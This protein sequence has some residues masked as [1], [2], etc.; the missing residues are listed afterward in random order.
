MASWVQ[1]EAPST[2]AQWRATNQEG[3]AEQ[4][5]LGVDALMPPGL[6]LSPSGYPN[7]LER[8]V[9]AIRRAWRDRPSTDP[10]WF[11]RLC[12][13]DDWL[14]DATLR[15]FAL[16]LV[17]DL[18]DEIGIALHTRFGRRAAGFDQAS[19]EALREFV[20]VLAD[21]GRLIL[22]LQS[23]MVGWLSLAWGAWGFS[24]GLSQTSWLDSREEIRRRRGSR[25]PA[26]LER[27]FEPQLLH[28]VLSSDHTQLS[29]QNGYRSCSCTFCGQ[30]AQGWDTRV[31]GQHD[32]YA[33]A[34]LTQ[35]VA[36]GDR[37]AR[38]DAVRDILEA[39]QNRWA[40]WSATPGLSPRARPAQLATW[41]AVV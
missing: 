5:S 6:E 25:S 4:R 9:D 33:L 26:R 30:L 39:A 14:T 11:A 35:R 18:P 41:R 10:A 3:L 24:A 31:A 34:D 2:R 38:R 23:G 32:L 12:L 37:T 15:R 13:H 36:V 29:R 27:Y 7:A 8:Q 20:R 21:D 16:N 22:T 40:A 28:H 19:L 17:T 1:R